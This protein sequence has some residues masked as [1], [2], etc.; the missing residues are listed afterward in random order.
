MPSE[1]LCV[2]VLLFVLTLEKFYLFVFHK[3]SFS[4]FW[5]RKMKPGQAPMAQLEAQHLQLEG[6]HGIIDRIISPGA[7]SLREAELPS[8]STPFGI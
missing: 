7:E 2:L 8:Q 1:P 5:K 3:D 6:P 4:H